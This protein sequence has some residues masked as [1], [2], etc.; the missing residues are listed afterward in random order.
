MGFA[1]GYGCRI[2][3][4]RPGWGLRMTRAGDGKTVIRG[5]YGLFYDR[6]PGNL[7]SQSSSFNST[8]TPLVILAG[9]SPCT[10]ASTVSP[11]NLNAT[12]TFQGTLWQCKLSAGG[13][14]ELP[15]GAAEIRSE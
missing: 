1:K 13:Q 11:T 15:G 3:T 14:P 4:S 6:A 8:R 9:G 10:A 5:N 7:Q 2:I 12:N